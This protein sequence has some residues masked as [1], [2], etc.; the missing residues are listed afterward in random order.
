MQW[1]LLEGAHLIRYFVLY[2]N[3]FILVIKF[4]Y[5]STLLRVWSLKCVNS[6]QC[7]AKQRTKAASGSNVFQSTDDDYYFLIFS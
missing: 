3:V 6:Y 5:T 4:K 2:C 7:L 1:W